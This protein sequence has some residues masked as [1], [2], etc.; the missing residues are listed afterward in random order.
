MTNRALQDTVVLCVIIKH[1][2]IGVEH[3][4]PAA[5]GLDLCNAAMPLL[6]QIWRTARG[7]I[8]SCASPDRTRT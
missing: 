7:R 3:S 4:A 6:S 2:Q 5:C 8:H 1:F